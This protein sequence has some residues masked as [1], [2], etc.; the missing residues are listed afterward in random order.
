MVSRFTWTRRRAGFVLALATASALSA[1]AFAADVTK[2]DNADNLE[3]TTSWVGGIAPT[4]ADV[5]LFNSTLASNSA[6]TLGAAQTWGGIR[7][8][9]PLVG[10][11]T[12][13]GTAALT[14][15][16]FGVD[17][18][19]ATQDLTINTPVNINGGPGVYNW[20]VANGRTLTLANL[21]TK[22]GHT[23][24]QT[25]IVKFSTTG[26]IQLPAP[27][28]FN[29]N[30]VLFSN[31]NNPYALYGD[32]DWAALDATGRVVAATYTDT[33]TAMTAGT[34]ANVA[35]D[36]TNFVPTAGMDIN[37]LRFNDSTFRTIAMNAGRTF[38]ARGILMTANSG[39]GLISGGFI[40]PSRTASGGGAPTLFPIIQNSANNLEISSVF[41]NASSST[42]VVIGKYGSG[43]LILSGANG[44]GGGLVIAQGTVEIGGANGTVSGNINNLSSLIFNRSA[45]TLA[46]TQVISGNGSIEYTGAG[47]YVLSG[48]NTY[49][50]ANNINGGFVEATSAAALGTSN[51]LNF[52]GGGYR[53]NA[54]YTPDLTTFTHTVG[55]NGVAID[56]NGSNVAF[57][58]NFGAGS[59]GGLTKVGAGTLTL[60]G[61]TNYGGASTVNGG[62]LLVNGSTGGGATVA[63]GGTLGGS[64]TLAG[65]VVVSNGA[66]LQP[67]NNGVG[68][69]TVGGL[70]LDTGSILEYGFTASTR[71]KVVVTGNN[72]LTVNGG[73]FNLFNDGTT[74]PYSTAGSYQLIQFAGGVQ[75]A[76][77]SALS[78]LNPAPGKGY[79][80]SVVGNNVVLTI[81]NLGIAAKWNVDASGSW[82]TAGNW[83]G[84]IPNGGG[85]T[86][87][88][89]TQLTANRTVTLDGNKTI[90]GATFNTTN[91]GYTIA[92]GTGGTLTFGNGTN[93]ALFF[94]QG[95]TNAITAPVAL[96]SSAIIDVSSASASLALNGSVS[97]AGGLTKSGPG[98]LSLGNAN[99]TYAGATTV[100][101]GTLAIASMTSLGTNNAVNLSGG[102][103]IKYSAGMNSDLS[104]DKTVTV[105]AGGGGIDTNGNNVQF[106]GPI[107]GTGGLIKAGAGTLT[108]AA[109]NTY[110][111]ETVVRGGVLNVGSNDRLGDTS[112]GAGLT[113]DGGTLE[114]ASSFSTN[115]G[116]PGR[117]LTVGS[118]GGGISVPSG[119]TLTLNGAIAGSGLLTVDGG[120]QVIAN[121]AGS[122]T[123]GVKITGNSFVTHAVSGSLGTGTVEL[124]SGALTIGGTRLNNTLNVTGVAGLNGGSGSGNA[125][126]TTVIGNGDLTINN[127]GGVLDFEGDMTA[128]TGTIRTVAA[129]GGGFRLNGTT[130]GSNL[131]LDIGAGTEVR[132]RNTTTSFN[133]GALTG[134]GNLLSVGGGPT[135]NT[136]Y[137]IGGKNINATFDG[138]VGD[139][140]NGTTGAIDGSTSITKVGT[141]TQIFNGENYY[142]GNTVIQAG[143]L[144]LGPNAHTPIFGGNT[145][146]TGF[147]VAG[148]GADIQGG[149]LVLDYTGTSS[150]AANVLAILDAG[151]DQATKFSTGALRSTTLAAN[152]L[153][154][155]KEDASNSTVTIA[156]TLAGDADLSFNVNFD[157][158]LVLA[159]NYN[160]TAT[161]KVWSQGD[162]NYDGTVNFDDLL[163]L[164]QNY[165]GSALQAEAVAS[166]FGAE[167][168]G[169]WARAMSL[170]PEPASL[171][172]LAGGLMLVRRRRD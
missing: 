49:T 85:D 23:A 152:R 95:G 39:G 136:T 98:T 108:L 161:G 77:T 83:Q 122:H 4:V 168:A 24:N 155:W 157:D 79:A 169:E 170:V 101:G 8:T 160:P 33:T 162:F 124:A 131:T 27:A 147:P 32:N 151:Y 91:F 144:Q 88:F 159:Q 104:T 62:R 12:I 84:G 100:N 30:T 117:T 74:D 68:T 149:K 51:T 22:A 42:P 50:A 121:I 28:T 3:L 2:A 116:G 133:I 115:D 58:G 102:G 17:M 14:I 105:G 59:S 103:V 164:A 43:K 41:A 93:N 45:G 87:S 73:G 46:L 90:G 40:R 129:G 6:W 16:A 142:T 70:T 15:G 47:T 80:F 135:G 154:G 38:T 34:N 128:Y 123:G 143:T 158:L 78:V 44:N 7:V 48:A 132:R 130:L 134:Q 113:L 60:N 153:L 81:T 150:P 66:T 54:A 13:N 19:A 119:Q 25:G 163:G 118:A 11:F 165:G 35:S 67:G 148:A 20:T 127:T 72:A 140:V 92:Q 63:N 55:A 75:G 26:T 111:G 171:S 141:G 86:A 37:S 94:V 167:F 21:P 65:T 89:T 64:G 125:D 106:N 114:V 29:A 71:D 56:T 97:G 10:P 36:L 156:H 112:V 138:I 126:L 5:A 31:A 82:N 18:S 99:N 137:V 52:N 139:S 109:P 96:A 110:T 76:G 172:L 166:S 61:T 145:P 69:L 120:G 9:N 107:S 53:Y 1:P 57:A 146:I